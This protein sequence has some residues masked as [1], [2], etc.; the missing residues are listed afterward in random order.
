PI[1][2]MST[3]FGGVAP[4]MLAAQ[5][6]AAFTLALFTIMLSMLASCLV[7][8]TTGAVFLAFALNGTVL[9]LLYL[10]DLGLKNTLG[11]L[12]LGDLFIEFDLPV[13]R[14]F[15]RALIILA[16]LTTACAAAILAL[17][18][19]LAID[20]PRRYVVGAPTPY[21]HTSRRMLRWGPVLPILSVH[22]T[23]LTSSLRT[24]TVRATVATFLTIVGCVPAVGTIVVVMLLIH[25]ITASLI[26]ARRSGA[27]DDLRVTLISP[28][29]LARDLVSFYWRRGLIYVPALMVCAL[30]L[31]YFAD[32][33]VLSAGVPVRNWDETSATVLVV[34]TMGFVSGVILLG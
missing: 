24:P 2:F 12:A 13:N 19:R 10:V 16:V 3:I 25:E 27:L 23:G 8:N 33:V 28:D 31:G 17:I 9:T 6:L 32:R 21:G 20:R 15:F 18:P 7:R 26:A 11:F 29:T 14:A 1:Q 30:Q 5:S 34:Y 22:A 4:D